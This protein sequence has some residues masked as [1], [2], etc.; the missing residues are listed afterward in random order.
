VHG[1]HSRTV[2]GTEVPSSWKIWVMPTFRPSSPTRIVSLRS[3]H[4]V[5][6][7]ASHR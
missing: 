5:K 7:A 6:D 4:D 3:L 1:P 2:M